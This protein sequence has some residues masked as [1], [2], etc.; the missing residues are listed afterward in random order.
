M[1]KPIACTLTTSDLSSQRARWVE[2][3]ERTP[4]ERLELPNGLRLVFRA[5]PGVSAELEELVAVERVCCAFA[6]WTLAPGD[7]STVLDITAADEAVPV[8]QSMFRGRGNG[9]R[10][11]LRLQQTHD[12]PS[13]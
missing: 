8:V 5:A 4:V 6:E 10:F 11:E 1:R 9:E 12:G 2:L 7:E 3:A 13:G